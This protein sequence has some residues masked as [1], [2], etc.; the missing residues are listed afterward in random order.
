MTA[1]TTDRADRV[2]GAA[3]AASEAHAADAARA[4]LTSGAVDAVVAGVFAAAAA[5]RGV[6]F[7]PVQLLVGGPGMG[8]RAVDGRPRQPGIGAPRPRGFVAGEAIPPAS[9]A[10]SP[11][12][13]ATLTATLA[14]SGN[15]TLAKVMAPAIAIAKASSP[16]RAA[17]LASVARRGAAAL[18]DEAIAR[19]LVGA[20]GRLAG[21]VLTEDDLSSLRPEVISLPAGPRDG[22]RVLGVPWPA[23]GAS[24]RAHVVAAVD[25]RGRAAIAC[26]EVAEDGVLVDALDLVMPPFAEPVMRG[27]TRVRPGEARPAA[28]PILLVESNGALEAAWGLPFAATPSALDALRGAL[29]GDEALD[30]ASLASGGAVGVAWSRAGARAFGGA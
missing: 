18:T 27:Q 11:A 26:Y 9:R 8:L 1:R 22:R 3:V 10:A 28:A 7:G 30:G 13:I 5:S 23:D 29:G 17:V 21:G 6:L 12:L 19:E 20:A 14:T 24:A 25:A 16:E 4:L 15:A 2:P